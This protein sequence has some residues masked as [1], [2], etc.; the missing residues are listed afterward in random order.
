M[1]KDESENLTTKLGSFHLV[2]RGQN[3][4]KPL[5]SIMIMNII[6]MPYKAGPIK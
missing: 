5:Y 4:L 3:P 1:S 6:S 2:D